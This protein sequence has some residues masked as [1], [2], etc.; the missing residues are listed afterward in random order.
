MPSPTDGIPFVIFTAVLQQTSKLHL[1]QHL[2][3][4]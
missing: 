1:N 3:E 2:Y 4:Y